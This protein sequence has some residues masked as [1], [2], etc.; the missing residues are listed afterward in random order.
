MD[1]VSVAQLLPREVMLRM[2]SAVRG[3]Y[4]GADSEKDKNYG[5]NLT[6]FDNLII[7]NQ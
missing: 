4:F 6:G 7:M 5:Q 1:L 2:H 3:L